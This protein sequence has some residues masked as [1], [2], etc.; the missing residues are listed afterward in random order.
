MGVGHGEDMNISPDS[1]EPEMRR[2]T[3]LPET[4]VSTV[5]TGPGWQSRWNRSEKQRNEEEEEEEEEER[6]S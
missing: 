4:S 3:E 5:K 2:S 1:Y 6:G